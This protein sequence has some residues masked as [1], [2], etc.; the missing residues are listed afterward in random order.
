M[1]KFR[2]EFW[3]E[4]AQDCLFENGITDGKDYGEAANRVTDYYG[5]DNIV[6]MELEEL[7]NIIISDEVEHIFKPQEIKDNEWI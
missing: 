4:E 7:N 5:R 1:F 6:N 2:V 3:D